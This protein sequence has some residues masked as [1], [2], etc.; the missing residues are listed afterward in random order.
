M[1]AGVFHQ[2]NVDPIALDDALGELAR[3]EPRKSQI[4]EMQISP[5]TVERD[6]TFARTL[7]FNALTES[8]KA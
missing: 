7:L 2:P 3:A 8:G 4:A 6:W 5:A 1:A